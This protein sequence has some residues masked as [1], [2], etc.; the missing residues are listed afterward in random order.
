[1][2]TLEDLQRPEYKEILA[3]GYMASERGYISS[4]LAFGE[5][6]TQRKEDPW[7]ILNE[8][9]DEFEDDDEDDPFW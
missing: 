4:I 3:A 7:K 8:L 5:L 6:V 9:A 1:M 2:V